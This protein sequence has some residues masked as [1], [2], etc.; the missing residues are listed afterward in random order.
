METAGPSP[1]QPTAPVNLS[2]N[3]PGTCRVCGEVNPSGELFCDNCGTQLWA[4]I[5]AGNVPDGRLPPGFPARSPAKPIPQ[6]SG[7]GFLVVMYNG[8]I[9]GL[10]ADKTEVLIG[11][12]D[13]AQGILPDIDLSNY[14]GETAGVSRQHARLILQNG[15]AFIED[16][17]S[18][19]ATF[20]N[21]EKL[22]PGEPHPLQPG[23]QVMLGWLSITYS[24]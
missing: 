24:V 21:Q 12:K 18:D 2:T 11:R 4:D 9:I 6:Y 17:N 14:N 10:P 15:Q 1:V 13:A 23:D 19:N 16:L 7:W 3:A 8:A 5:P 22:K 20:V